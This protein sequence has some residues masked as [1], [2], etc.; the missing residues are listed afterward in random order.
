MTYGLIIEG[1]NPILSYN[2]FILMCISECSWEI[3]D[4]IQRF[5]R[6]WTSEKPNIEEPLLGIYLCMYHH[7]C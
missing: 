7:G 4:L 3:L 1:S 6:R 2:I 5:Y